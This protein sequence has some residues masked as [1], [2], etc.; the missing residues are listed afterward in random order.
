MKSGL[1][2]ELL[3]DE[4]ENW[5]SY[6]NIVLFSY[7]PLL[8]CLPDLFI[9]FLNVYQ[10]LPPLIGKLTVGKAQPLVLF[11]SFRQKHIDNALF[12][13]QAYLF[14]DAHLP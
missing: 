9:E 10:N 1:V 13:P 12:I 6:R 8:V 5:V 7:V 14:H 11:E 2:N 3:V 4:I